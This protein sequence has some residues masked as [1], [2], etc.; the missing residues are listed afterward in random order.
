MISKVLSCLALAAAASAQVANL[1][2]ALTSSPDLSNLTAIISAFPGLLSALEGAS[3]ITILAPSNEAFQDLEGT[4][5]EAVAA[6]DTT[7]IQSV[8]TYHVL[9]GTYNS[10]QIT[11]L[12]TFV[13]THLTH[14]RFANVTDGQRVEAL[15]TT[16]G[17]V[18]FSGLLQNSTVTKAVS[19]GKKTKQKAH[20]IQTG[21]CI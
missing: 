20:L 18:F 15:N 4:V 7:A 2:S 9:N 10:S 14:E 3:N 17:V 21:C 8:L 5:A 11:D 19:C 6:N 1:T 16:D 12:P 13:P